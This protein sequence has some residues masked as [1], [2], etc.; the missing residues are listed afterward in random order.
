M[1][2]HIYTYIYIYIYFFI[3]YD[4]GEWIFYPQVI[5]NCVLH[6]MISVKNDN[7]LGDVIFKY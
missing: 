3:Y 5:G 7:L 4:I 2:Q 1:P 6:M